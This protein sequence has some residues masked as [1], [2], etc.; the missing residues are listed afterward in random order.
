[1]DA[2]ISGLKFEGKKYISLLSNYPKIVFSYKRENCI[3]TVKK[4]DMTKLSESG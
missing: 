4:L 3:F 1:M 2:K